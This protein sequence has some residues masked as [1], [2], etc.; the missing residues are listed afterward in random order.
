MELTKE[1]KRALI[2]AHPQWRSVPPETRQA[3]LDE[4]RRRGL[5]RVIGLTPRGLAVRAQI[6]DEMLE[7]L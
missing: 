7:A 4:L 2:N 6:L 1:A 5:I 3:V